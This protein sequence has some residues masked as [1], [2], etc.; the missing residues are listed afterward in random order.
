MI[1]TDHEFAEQIR[2]LIPINGLELWLQKQV[3]AQGELVPFKRKAVVFEEGDDDPYSLFLVD[4]TLEMRSGDLTPTNMTAGEGDALRALAQ[5]RPRRYTARCT[6]PS[7]M[8]RIKRAQLEHILSDEQVST[9]GAGLE[10]AGPQGT[11]A[12]DGVDWMSKLLASELMT[13]LPPN[14]I[15]R[16]FAELEPVPVDDGDVVVEQGTPG[17]FLYIVAEGRFAV[18]RRLP[19]A[20]Q[21]QE[22]ATLTPGQVFGEE[23]LISE[24]PRNATVLAVGVG[25]VMRLGKASFEELVSRV[26]LKPVT[27]DDAEALVKEGAI[28]LDVRFAEEFHNI[29]L[30]DAINLPLNQLRSRWSE[31]DRDKEYIAYCDSGGRGSTA[32]FV[33]ARYQIDA[34]YLAGGLLHSPYAEM[35]GGTLD[36]MVPPGTILNERPAT[37]RDFDL[38]LT[39]APSASSEPQSEATEP[40]E[41]LPTAKPASKGSPA[42]GPTRSAAPKSSGSESA[43]QSPPT[44]APQRVAVDDGKLSAL[45]AE[46]AT[47]VQ[48]LE[49]E[50]GRHEG[51]VAKA[52]EQLSKLKQ[53]R[54]KIA[55]QAE[56]AVRA[57]RQLKGQYDESGRTLQAEKAR[58]EGLRQRHVSEI[59][60]FERCLEMETARLENEQEALQGRFK[61]LLAEHQALQASKDEALAKLQSA[62]DEA[63]EEL[64]GAETGHTEL[65]ARLTASEGELVEVRNQLTEELEFATARTAVL[66]AECSTLQARVDVLE[67][68]F[69]ASR[70][71]ILQQE[72]ELQ[73]AV[74]EAVENENE[75]EQLDAARQALE[76]E[77]SKIHAAQADAEQSSATLATGQSELTKKR[78]AHDIQVSGLEA[79]RTRVDGLSQDLDARAAKLEEAEAAREDMAAELAQGAT[80]LD[81]QR[82]EL[83][84]D[85]VA[86]GERIEEAVGEER[87][88]IERA[89]E[90][91][92]AATIEIE[93]ARASTEADAQARA[94]E[95][96]RDGEALERRIQDLGELQGRA[97]A[98]RERDETDFERRQQSL[99]RAQAALGQERASVEQL[100]VEQERVI[101]ERIQ[102]GMAQVGD[103][104]VSRIRAAAEKKLK[105]QAAL[106]ADQRFR[107]ESEIVRLREAVE[108][109]RPPAPAPAPAAQ[110]VDAFDEDWLVVPGADEPLADRAALGDDDAPRVVSPQQ[111]AAIRAK[112]NEK[113]AAL[114]K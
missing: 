99:E 49:A 47:T 65:E 2:A 6:Q 35:V 72:S 60:E 112:M 17:D 76:D 38:E 70:Q 13:R 81:Q 100:A 46:L 42:A 30:K 40:V 20:S 93:A 16:F 51:A 92:E 78:D 101:A 3:F 102:E 10:D 12:D 25:L 61:G 79:E 22:L 11:D 88:R 9:E 74:R 108:S 89:Q 54:D 56:K 19:G 80:E 62:L 68:R 1:P 37:A 63:R 103:D 8:F 75:E 44:A 21:V 84:A 29:A 66:E 31:L 107:L 34:H 58:A 113:M 27:F 87:A 64:R 53:E 23:A 73:D 82:A 104:R 55:G 109:Q 71:T 90:S 33:L 97:D 95:L 26:T 59:A 98:A 106:F 105:E 36:M 83:V 69:E 28:W 32:A 5:L 110:T 67:A 24:L 15:A 85:Q 94:E 43:P 114:R 77:W 96:D 57:A 111:L 18:V 4:G 86:W 45:R 41:T 50:R 14:N 52:R 39:G 91:L 48:Q 7:T